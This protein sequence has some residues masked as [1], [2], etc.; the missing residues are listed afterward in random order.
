MNSFLG[1]E[2]SRFSSRPIELYHF[3]QGTFHWYYTSAGTSQGYAGK[4]YIPEI[5]SSTALE[6]KTDDGEGAVDITVPDSNPIAAK[7][8][9]GMPAA[10]IWV[11]VIRLQRGTNE[12]GRYF[13]GQITL[14]TFKAGGG[15]ATL[16][17]H[18]PLTALG[19]KVPRN[20]YQT[21]CNRVLYRKGCGVNLTDY[22]R[23]VTITDIQ[24]DRLISPG[25]A[26]LPEGWLNLGHIWYQDT[27]RMITAH[28]GDWVRVLA[29]APEFKIGATVTACA[30]C[31]HR[32][33]TCKN[34]FNNLIN[35]FGWYT[36]PKK[37]PFEDGIG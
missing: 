3:N 23:Q 36:M 13:R 32:K 24:D 7:F 26:T 19:F 37:N 10:P 18:P 20:L 34:K 21:F 31:D 28:A 30:G 14:A 1:L 17:C 8:A 9:A 11:E 15:E 6:Q 27:Y 33:D 2:L 12:T 22:S 25:F 29:M 5:I 4:A 35:F 16:Q